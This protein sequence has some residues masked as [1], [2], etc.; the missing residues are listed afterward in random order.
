MDETPVWDDMVSNTT[1]D[2]VGATSVNLK[3]TGHEKVMVTVCLSARAD[4]TKLKPFIVFRGAKQESK[5]LN[6]DYKHKCV[7]A[8]SANAWM[9]E[10][11]TLNWVRSVLGAFSFN[12]RLLA[13]NSYECHMMQSVKEALSRINVDQVIIPGGCTKY[14]QAPDV[15]WNKPFK[16]LV[17]EQYDEWMAS[18]VQ[19][20]TEAGNIR[21]PS[22]KT[23]VEWVLTAWSR[24]SAD[25]ISK[26]FK[27]CALN[28][29]VDG[30]ED[31]MIHC[32]KKGQ[33]CE[34]GSDQLQAQL[35]VLDEPNLPN[36]FIVVT[37]SDVEEANDANLSV[38][39]D[40]DDDDDIDVEL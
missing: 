32:F 25:V 31:S 28:L 36:P 9:N 19:E 18:G 35:S 12:R 26:S 37:D 22:R 16:A 34:A 4:R 29:A 30:T 27:S 5:K 10:A 24:L 23:I 1:V 33:P 11:L 3:T 21:P 6:E 15:S 39:I 8:T 7:I 14:V 40:P 20:Y 17:A 2:K 38:A 13:W